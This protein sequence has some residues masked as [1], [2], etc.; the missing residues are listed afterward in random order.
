M[1]FRNN[2]NTSYYDAQNRLGVS[3]VSK[4]LGYSNRST[5]LLTQI[6]SRTKGL[7]K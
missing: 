2:Y 3:N 4:G 6:Q 5:Y 7:G 1:S